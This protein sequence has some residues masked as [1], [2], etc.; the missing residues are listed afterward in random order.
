MK[1]LLIAILALLSLTASAQENAWEEKAQAATTQNN[2]DAKYMA[3]AGPEVDGKVVFTKVI[4]A[5]GKTAQQL[6]DAL[7]KQMEYLTKE[8]NQVQ[9]YQSR[10]V[11]ADAEKKQLIGSYQEW[12]VFKNTALVLDRTR[13]LYHL[14]GECSDGEV[15]LSLTRI[16]YIYEEERDPQT[17]VAE[18]WITDKQGLNKKQ[19][20][21]A[22]VSGKFRRK[23]IDRKDFIF[24]K[25]N[26]SLTK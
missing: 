4:K 13:F 19:T 7:L 11:I 20:K 9:P 10:M 5:P 21:L 25:L 15:K 14:I 18:D 26:Q 6:Y 24:E 8:Q 1:K 2:P 22:R 3:G 23:T 12:L 17:I 16:V